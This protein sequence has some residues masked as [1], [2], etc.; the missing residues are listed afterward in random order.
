M[1]YRLKGLADN[2]YLIQAEGDIRS[3][4]WVVYGMDRKKLGLLTPEEAEERFMA[5]MC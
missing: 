1:E 2:G 3:L 5:Q 4:C